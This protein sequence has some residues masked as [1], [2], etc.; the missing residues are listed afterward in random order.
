MK[1]IALVGKGKLTEKQIQLL[2]KALKDEFEITKQIE[3]LQTPKDIPTDIDAV[4]TFLAIPAVIGT[5]NT[6]QKF[7]NK[8]CYLFKIEQIGTFDEPQPELEDA[9]IKYTKSANGF[10]KYVYSKTVSVL[11]NPKIKF[12]WEE[13]IT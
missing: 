10:M 11:K 2:K 8:P 4:V 5:I 3:T 9:D 13:E 12:E 1:K 7:N 6:W